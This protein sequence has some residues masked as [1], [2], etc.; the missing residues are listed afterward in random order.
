[1]KNYKLK[2]TEMLDNKNLIAAIVLSIAI[3][4]GFQFL[5]GVP[6]NE[7]VNQEKLAQKENQKLKNQTSNSLSPPSLEDNKD[8]ESASNLKICSVSLGH[9]SNRH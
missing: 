4:L 8:S 9:I 1:M 6:T 7:A 2:I 3:I 5:Y